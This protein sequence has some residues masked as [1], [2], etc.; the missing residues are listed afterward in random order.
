MSDQG[1]GRKRSSVLSAPKLPHG[2]KGEVGRPEAQ[3]GRKNAGASAWVRGRPRS[4]GAFLGAIRGLLHS[5]ARLPP[6][7]PDPLL[8]HGE[9]VEVGRPEAQNELRNA[10]ASQK[11]YPCT[12]HKRPTRL[13]TRGARS[14]TAWVRGR[15][16]S[17][18][19]FLG[20][21]RGLLHSRARLPPLP[22]DPLLP[23]G[24]KVEVGRP[25]G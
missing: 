14:P 10:G 4:R 9:K 11:T 23:H 5:R 18:G 15:P 21:I 6:L 1:Q 25:D 8:P 7:P 2:E 3:N 12:V 16:R 22:P 13:P 24:E 19:A 20:A 17:R